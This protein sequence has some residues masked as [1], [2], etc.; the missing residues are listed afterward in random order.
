MKKTLYLLDHRLKWKTF[1]ELND[2]IVLVLSGKNI[3]EKLK[4]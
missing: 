3:Y 4:P 1:K 2:K